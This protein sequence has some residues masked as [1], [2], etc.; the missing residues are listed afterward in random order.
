MTPVKYVC[1]GMR[2]VEAHD[3]E[4][5][6]AIFAERLARRNSRTSKVLCLQPSSRPG[7]FVAETTAR[8][9]TQDIYF[10]VSPKQPQPEPAGAAQ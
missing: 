4:A 6:A 1:A 9:A 7:V 3:I 5:A 2:P 8:G 10:S